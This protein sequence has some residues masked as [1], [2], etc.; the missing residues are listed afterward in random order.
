M[1]QVCPHSLVWNS[2]RCKR[3]F[4]WSRYVT[5]VWCGGVLGIEGCF[6]GSDVSPQFGVEGC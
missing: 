4:L 5:T 2:V 3:V 1:V 6:S